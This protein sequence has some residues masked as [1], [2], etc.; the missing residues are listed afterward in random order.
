MV[1]NNAVIYCVTRIF[2]VRTSEYAEQRQSTLQLRQPSSRLGQHFS[3][4][5]TLSYSRAVSSSLLTTIIPLQLI[6]YEKC[7]HYR[8]LF[9]C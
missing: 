7:P 8:Q 6:L 3:R 2:Q 4:H 5:E 1:F 9:K